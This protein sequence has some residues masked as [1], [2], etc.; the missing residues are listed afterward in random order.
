MTISEKFLMN[1]ITLNSK[2]IGRCFSL[3]FYCKQGPFPLNTYNILQY[4]P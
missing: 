1:F 3:T 2:Q 4:Y